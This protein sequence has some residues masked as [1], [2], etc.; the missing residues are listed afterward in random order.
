VDID[1]LVAQFMRIGDLPLA[2]GLVS[3]SGRVVYGYG[4]VSN[5]N[6]R[7]PDAGTPFEIGSVS[8]V[9]TGLLLAQMALDRELSLADPVAQHLEPEARIPAFGNA[10]IT[11]LSLATHTSGLPRMSP[12]AVRARGQGVPYGITDLYAYLAA[13]SLQS[14]P[15]ERYEYSNIGA[16]LLGHALVVRARAA[17]YAALLAARITGPLGMTDTRVA[18]TAESWARAARPVGRRNPSDPPNAYMMIDGGAGGIKST[19][20]D[21]LTL[22]AA[23]AGVR[24]SLL[25]PAIELA[26]TARFRI[27]PEEAVGLFWDLD[28]K[29]GLISKDGEVNG[30][31]TYLVVSRERRA[32]VIV[33]LAEGGEARFRKLARAA[34]ELL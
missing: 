7:P 32:A 34:L 19:P 28:L 11:L 3:A 8:K 20:D 31:V 13:A 6:A 24:P 2:V 21:L 33:C 30:S 16:G 23:V 4:R 5:A 18:W 14:R 26:T 12:A 10:P 25:A 29:S 17:D 1:A 27:N 9:F 15:G 22:G